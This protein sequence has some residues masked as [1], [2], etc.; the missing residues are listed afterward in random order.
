[1]RLNEVG[2]SCLRLGLVGRGWVRLL[3]PVIECREKLSKDR[4]GWVR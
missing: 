3:E 1:M 2:K 4:I